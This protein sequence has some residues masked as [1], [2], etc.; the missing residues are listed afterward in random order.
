M[1]TTV[2]FGAGPNEPFCNRMSGNNSIKAV[3]RNG[4][5][6]VRTLAGLVLRYYVSVSGR[7]A[8]T[9]RQVME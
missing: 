8:L 9:W 3:R 6:P 5:H 7:E 4:T 1:A 2:F